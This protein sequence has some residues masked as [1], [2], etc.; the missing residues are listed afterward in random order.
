[1][2]RQVRLAVL[3]PPGSRRAAYGGLCERLKMS[4]KEACTVDTLVLL[5]ELELREGNAL[6]ASCVGVL[7]WV[8]W[9]ARDR[10]EGQ[11]SCRLSFKGSPKLAFLSLSLA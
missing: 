1:V 7:E 3:V 5:Q 10:S 11:L 6:D 8:R 2:V 9:Y 4:K